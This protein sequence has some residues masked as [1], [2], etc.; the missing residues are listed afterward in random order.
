MAPGAEIYAV[1][2][3]NNQGSGTLANVAS[4]IIHAADN[5][6]KVISLSLGSTSGASTLQNAVNYAWNR[7]AVVV[8]AAG[9]AGNTAPHYPA[10]YSNAISVAATD[11]N[12]R[13]AS[14]LYLWQLGR[15]S[16]ARS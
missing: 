5:G 7:G 3:L 6:S 14:F 13:S 16:R 4:G 15:C 12:D 8:A 10:Y 11:S 9:N 2:V 1:K